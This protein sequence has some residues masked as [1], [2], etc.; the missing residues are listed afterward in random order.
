MWGRLLV[1]KGALSLP[2]V[3]GAFAVISLT[4]INN[5]TVTNYNCRNGYGAGPPAGPMLGSGTPGLV[6]QELAAWVASVVMTRGVA[7]DAA[8]AAPPARKG[9]RARQPVQPREIS[10]T[11]ARRAVIAAIRLGGTSYATLPSAFAK[12][13]A[14]IDRNRTAPAR[15][16]APAPSGYASRT[17]TATRIAGAV[18]KLAKQAR[19]TRANTPRPPGRT[20]RRTVESAVT[21]HDTPTSSMPSQAKLPSVTTI[22]KPEPPPKPRKC[23][24]PMAFGPPGQVGPA[25]LGLAP[26]LGFWGWR[27]PG[28][29]RFHGRTPA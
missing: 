21:W 23:P 13:R 4:C 9:R 6:R 2:F 24:K 18:I 25:V 16:N 22:G 1:E 27:R 8:L 12:C 29:P 7:R 5:P 19:L 3:T 20:A 15:R 11:A 28:W 10:H 14:L 17:D 26:V